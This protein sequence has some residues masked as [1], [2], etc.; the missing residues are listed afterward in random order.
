MTMLSINH[1]AKGIIMWT[2]PTTPELVT[3]TSALAA[4]LTDKCAYLLLG[5]HLSSG[6][7]IEG[8]PAADVSFWRNENE[9]LLSIVNPS[10]EGVEGLV[11][12]QLPITVTASSFISLWGDD[13]WKGVD[14]CVGHI[15]T[16]QKTGLRALSVDVLLLSLNG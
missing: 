11:E 5:A 10:Y 14:D 7:A 1:G 16:L 13:Q 4:M 8:A 15:S 6:F 2:F 3:V 9:M 12:F